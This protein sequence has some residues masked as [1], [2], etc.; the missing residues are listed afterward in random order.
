MYHP[1]RLLIAVIILFCSSFA[2]KAHG[3]GIHKMWGTAYTGGLNNDGTV[4]YVQFDGQAP[5]LKASLNTAGLTR[6][7]GSLASFNNKL[8]GI[9]RYGG[10]SD[11]GSIFEFDPYSNSLVRKF[12]FQ[13]GTGANPE[14]GLT[15]LNDILYGVCFYGGSTN[16]GVLYAYDPVA[17]SF[18][19]KK[20]LN[21]ATGF[22]P[23]SE[24][25]VVG[26][27][28]YGVTSRGGKHDAG[29]IFEY[30]PATDG[31]TIR[32]SF[33][34]NNGLSPCGNLVLFNNK[35]YGTAVNAGTYGKGTLWQFDIATGALT[36]L[37]QFNDAAHA[38]NGLT[39]H[40]GI[41]YG[42][43][44]KGGVDDNGVFYS[45]DLTA[46]R[47]TR[48]LDFTGLRGVY[49]TGITQ[50]Q[51]KLYILSND[52]G[53]RNAGT[54]LEYDPVSKSWTKKAD[55][56][57]DISGAHP[58]LV[59]LNKVQAETA[60][61]SVGTC[62]S[63]RAITIDATNANQWVPITDDK[64]NAVAEIKANGNI[65]GTVQTSV[66]IHSGASREDKAH[67]IYLDRNITIIPQFNPASAVDLRLYIR[68]GEYNK[69]RTATGST[70]LG[71]G[72]TTI[73]DM[74]I[75]RND[76]PCS[77]KLFYTAPYLMNTGGN[78]AKE[79][80]VLTTSVNSFSSFYFAGKL[81]VLLPTII[82][83]FEVMEKNK[84]VLLQ[85]STTEDAASYQY[86]IE[87]SGD[88]KKFES[89]A[90]VHAKGQGDQFYSFTDEAPL[91]ENFYRI[92]F[93]TR[94][95]KSGYTQVK[96]VRIDGSSLD[97]R[98]T[99]A[100]GNQVHLDI[101]SNQHQ[102]LN[103]QLFNTAGQLMAGHSLQLQKGYQQS[104]LPVRS[105]SPGVY[106][107]V[108]SNAREKRHLTFLK[109]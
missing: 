37:H 5:L 76:D 86:S 68:G 64:G 24:L 72:I 79:D 95:G 16:Q 7:V 58:S 83:S 85:W 90:L 108:F 29:V 89:I 109:K 40:N 61:A 30:D 12:D 92:Q 21:S 88:G 2:Y 23:A 84:H 14:S 77:D 65:L 93:T 73:G 50:Y 6:P 10:P 28:L 63:M 18:T 74:G 71:S 60:P 70:G 69:L 9:C 8:Y 102:V 26:N 17:S 75:Y 43:T 97:I 20:D 62:T 35:I 33:N 106:H 56:D 59:N 36:A 31:Y 11:N 39:L 41:L 67:N 66:F 87:R 42:V 94:D 47:Y 38:Q 91:N 99:D 15:L 22:W 104:S 103:C 55:L 25:L 107:L 19:K 4:F 13:A 48:I 82:R 1:I 78:W 81:M 53:S 27:K 49:P 51:N 100:T 44:K 101:Y 80:Y 32:A 45:Y 46:S 98:V 96:K 34:G 105:I 54:V 3:Q 57:H 52:L